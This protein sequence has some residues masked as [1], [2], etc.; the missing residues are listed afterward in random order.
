MNGCFEWENSRIGW[1]GRGLGEKK[2]TKKSQGEGGGR[3]GT[4]R[5]EGRRMNKKC[6]KD[7]SRIGKEREGKRRKEKEKG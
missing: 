4:K 6:L 5:E 1:K 7:A 3:E 2:K